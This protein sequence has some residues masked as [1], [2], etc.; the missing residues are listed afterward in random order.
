MTAAMHGTLP[1]NRGTTV[2]VLWGLVAAGTFVLLAGCSSGDVEAPVSAPS[3][4]A[5]SA[6]DQGGEEPEGAA[7]ANGALAADGAL[8]TGGAAATDAPS[9]SGSSG[10][11]VLGNALEAFEPPALEELDATAD[12]QDRPVIDALDR[13]RRQQAENPPAKPAEEVLLLRNDSAEA[14]A[15]ILAAMRRVASASGDEV[16]YNATLVRHTSGDLKSANPLFAS[17]VTEADLESLTGIGFMSFDRDFEYFAPAS[18]VKSWQTSADGLMDKLVIRSDLTWS[19]GTPITA[20][21]V[22]FSFKLIMTDHDELVIPAVRTGTDQLRAVKAYDDHTLVYFHKEA[23][24][25]SQPN[26][27]FPVIP[28]HIYLESS[29]EDPSLKKSRRHRE[30]EDKPVVGGGYELVKRVRGQEFVVRR[31]EAFYMHNGQ[32]VRAKPYFEEVRVKVIEDHN[33]ALL[34]LKAGDIE[35]MELRAEQ[36]ES[37]TTEE[38]F[39]RH[40]TKVTDVEW[41]S[42][43]F[44]WNISSRYFNDKRVRWAMSYAFDYDELLKTICR[45]LYEQSQ[46]TFHPESWM[47][48][49]EGPQ[50]LV[51]D[52]DKAE[53]LLDEAGWGDSDGDG[54]RDKLIDGQL[55]PFEF[56]VMTY[57]SDTGIQAATLLKECLDQVGIVCHVKPTEFTV[58]QQKNLDHE[59]DCSMGGWGTA[60]DPDSSR[61][62]FA[63]GENRN[64]G[65]YSNPEVDALFEQGRREQ[66]RAKRAEIYGKIHLLMWEDQPYTWLFY[67]NS[68]FAFNKKLRGYSFS[69]RGPYSYSPGFD[70]LFVPLARP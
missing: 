60:T 18:T 24:A 15:K 50:P 17:S 53:D 33:T 40:N 13:E 3:V 11:L 58:M 19:D 63:T 4:R 41:T 34:A 1:G 47:F 49:A 67:R 6:E 25:T 52:L 26:M 38:D 23:L 54:I 64:Y 20:H 10:E 7:A 69:P 30:L 46:G 44:T 29:R 48:P 57:Q 55:V 62:I 45:G 66:D 8:A 21:D 65:L 12:W 31:R 59:F 68:F 22:E 32:Q 43:F 16:D 9:G 36:W 37:Q 70:S 61:N 35:E 56:S 27:I 42:F 39:Y 2:A 51:Q 28:R 14:N 5:G